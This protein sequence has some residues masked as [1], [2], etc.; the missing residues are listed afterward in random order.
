MLS[1]NNLAKIKKDRKRIGRGGDSGGTSGRGHKGQK[2]RSGGNIS[3]AFEGGQMALTRRLPK[4]G[5]KNTRFATE[6]CIVNL[7]D[8][9][10]HFEEGAL[11]DQESLAAKRLVK[12]ATR[13]HVKVLGK[14]VL[15]KKLTVQVQ[16]LSASAKEAITKAGGEI[17]AVVQGEP[18][19]GNAA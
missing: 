19:S 9:E 1:L 8:L 2:A 14:G 17:K 6:I 11:V 13:V 7:V 10:R 3:P 4:R 15:T 18:N 12:K 16:Q 5:F